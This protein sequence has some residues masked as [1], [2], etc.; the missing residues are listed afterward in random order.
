MELVTTSMSPFGKLVGLVN[1]LES[2]WTFYT[3]FSGLR[4]GVFAFLLQD[5]P[6]PWWL[7]PAIAL[8]VV[9]AT[10]LLGVA[11]GCLIESRWAFLSGAIVSLGMLFTFVA[12]FGIVPNDYL[13]VA[14]LLCV[15][16]AVGNALVWLREKQS[17]I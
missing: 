13:A 1:A 17:L 2:V 10:V 4:F 16:A 8:Q 5:P 12:M 7:V 15:V 14:I 6:A 9:F 11:Y 3:V